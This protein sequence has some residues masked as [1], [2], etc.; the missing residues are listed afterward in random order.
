[1]NEVIAMTGQPRWRASSNPGAPK[2]PPLNTSRLPLSSN[3]AWTSQAAVSRSHTLQIKSAHSFASHIRDTQSAK[4]LPG[5]RLILK[6]LPIK[7]DPGISPGRSTNTLCGSLV[8]YLVP[9]PIA[10]AQAA[11][12]AWTTPSRT[13]IATCNFSTRL[14]PTWMSVKLSSWPCSTICSISSS[15]T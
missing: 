3:Q 6:A 5:I 10:H 4:W 11:S 1:M 7:I 13:T 15:R 9:C 8:I 2:K 14:S 12:I